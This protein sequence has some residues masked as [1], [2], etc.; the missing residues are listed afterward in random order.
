VVQIS[1]FSPLDGRHLGDFPETDPATL[2]SQVATGRRAAALWS[3]VSVPERLRRL[4]P[5]RQRLIGDAERIVDCIRQCS[6]K[7]RSEALTGEL[8]PVLDLLG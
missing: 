3:A 8:Y 7:T 4:Q 1:A 2:R 5:L 6:G